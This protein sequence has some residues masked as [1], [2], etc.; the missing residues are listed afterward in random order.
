MGR[1]LTS[2]SHLEKTLKHI[3][4]LGKITLRKATIQEKSIAVDIDYQLDRIEHVELRR[5][6]KITKAI[7]NDECFFIL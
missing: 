1:P 6:E 3:V 4:D 2:A 5:E 7:L